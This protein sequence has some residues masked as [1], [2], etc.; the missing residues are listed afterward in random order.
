MVLTEESTVLVQSRFRIVIISGAKRTEAHVCEQN[1]KFACLFLQTHY[2]CLRTNWSIKIYPYITLRKQ[3]LDVYK[4][5][6]YQR[7]AFDV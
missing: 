5:I 4:P 7:L 3:I 6:L 2:L 1:F